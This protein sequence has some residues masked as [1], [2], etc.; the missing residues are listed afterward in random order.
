MSK[1]T[2]G[3]N[4]ALA[5]ASDVLGE[6]WT[7]LLVRDLLVAPRRFNELAE[8]LKGI[9]T[10]LLAKRLK[11]LEAAGILERVEGEGARAYALTDRGR[12]LEP[13]VLALI[14]WGLLHGPENREGD[15]HH[16]DWDLLALK[17]VFQPDRAAGLSL[18]V[19]FKSPDLQGW[20]GIADKQMSIGLGPISDPDIT[21]GGTVAEL[22]LGGEKP[23]R[24]LTHGAQEDLDRFVTSFAL[25]A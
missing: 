24:L 9:G 21:I 8:S 22:F 17:S 7:L 15:H 2:Y 5:R 4:C 11:E 18:T 14:R 10:N 23:A 19:Q 3:Q 12:A 25:R 6:R 20:C 16:D 13:S 1:R